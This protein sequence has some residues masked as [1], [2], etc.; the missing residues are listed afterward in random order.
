MTPNWEGPYQVTSKTE[1]DACKLDDLDGKKIPRA[2]NASH[3]SIL[4][5]SSLTPPNARTMS[6]FG[7]GTKNHPRSE[8]CLS[9]S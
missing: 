2:W 7:S 8:Q 4:Y 5:E 6:P 3:P 9:W 1:N